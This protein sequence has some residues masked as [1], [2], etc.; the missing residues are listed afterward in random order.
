MKIDQARVNLKER[1]IEDYLYENPGCVTTK[2]GFEVDHWIARQLQVPSGII[3]LLG[4]STANEAV[5]AE[6]KNVAVDSRALAQVCRY[7]KDIEEILSL[8]TNYGWPEKV[9]VGPEIEDTAIFEANALEIRYVEFSTQLT[10][11]IVGVNWTDAFMA[12]I[13]E[14]YQTLAHSGVFSEFEPATAPDAS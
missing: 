2:S 7:A 13:A 12:K 8:M 10:L 5:V 1:D 11:K 3:D 4:V 6:V 14:Q 9:V